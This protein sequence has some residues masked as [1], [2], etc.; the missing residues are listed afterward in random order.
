MTNPGYGKIFAKLRETCPQVW[1]DYTHHPFVEGLKDGSLPNESF[2][3]Y[4]KQDYVFLMHF[5]RAWALA[6]VKAETHSEM[7]VAVNTVNALISEEIQ[8]HVGI[9]KEA[10]ISEK[11]LFDTREAAA[12]LAY[13]RF[14]LEA[15]YSGDLLNLLAALTP[16][17][18]GY[19]EIGSRLGVERTS[20]TYGDW[21]DTYASGEYHGVCV[22]VGELIDSA[23]ERRIGLQ[24]EQSPR[25]P[26][27][28]DTFRIATELEVGFWQMG[29]EH[30]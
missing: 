10:G 8:L 13:T 5:S 25:W 3:H 16:C 7:L 30:R 26:Q 14:V 24:F 1:H 18:M 15:G 23:V 28:C 20:D 19:G 21:I 6:I 12:N 22:A 17:V 27:I 4:L 9:C 11:E 29:F 2:L